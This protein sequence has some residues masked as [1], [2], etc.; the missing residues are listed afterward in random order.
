MAGQRALRPDN[1][2]MISGV[3][4]DDIERAVGFIG[5]LSTTNA[6]ATTL[7]DGVVDDSV[8]S[9]KHRAVQMHD[10][11]S[12]DRIRVRRCQDELLHTPFGQVGEPLIGFACE[13]EHRSGGLN[14]DVE[15]GQV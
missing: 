12:F 1:H 14:K 6:K 8:M 7:P 4:G 10:L 15:R 2:A 13:R 9:A 5:V 11:A 3:Y